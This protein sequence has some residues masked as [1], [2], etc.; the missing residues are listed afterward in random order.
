MAGS[1]TGRPFGA[2]DQW[3][4]A[5]ARRLG[6]GDLESRVPVGRMRGNDEINE[7]ATSF[8]EMAQR[9]GVQQSSLDE[10]ARFTETVLHGVSSGV[11]GIDEN[12]D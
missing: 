3:L 12:G 9:L 1:V 2:A 7:L 6:D 10:R 4:I 8:N 11:I 5:A